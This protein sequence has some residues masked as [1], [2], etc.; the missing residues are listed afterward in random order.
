[1]GSKWFYSEMEKNCY[2][3]IMSV[4]KLQHYFEAHT[5]RVPT[6]QLLN[7]I[8]K[9]EIALEELVNGQWSYQSM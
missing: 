5:I 7:D 8:F 2:A 1:M 4:R 3:V 9:T 6:N